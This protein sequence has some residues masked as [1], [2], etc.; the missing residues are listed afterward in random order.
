MKFPFF[1]LWIAQ[2]C[3]AF[4]SAEPRVSL[5]VD[6]FSGWHGVT[7]NGDSATL[8]SGEIASFQYP[9][10][11]LGRNKHGFRV[12]H[13]G[14]RDWREFE[15][16]EVNLASEVGREI[17][18]EAT[19]LAPPGLSANERTSMKIRAK[20]KDILRLPWTLFNSLAA[21]TSHLKFIQGLELKGR[22]IDGKP[23]F[24]QLKSVTLVKG[25]VISLEAEIRGKSAAAGSAVEYDVL[26][27]NTSTTEQSIA[28][29]FLKY[30]WEAMTAEVE[31]TNF[32]LKSG[33]T[34]SCKVR[35]TT[36]GTIPPGG[37]EKQVLQAS[38]NGDAS[39]RIEFITGVIVPSPYLLHTPKRWDEVR[40]KVK[41]YP[42]AKEAQDVV[43]KRADD[44]KVP[45]I[46]KPPGNDPDDTMGPFLFATTNEHDLMSCAI[47]WQ[48]T[49]NKAHAEKVARFLRRLSDPVNGYPKTFRA[50]NQAQVQEGHFFQHIAMSYDMIRNADVL[51][52]QDCIQLEKTFRLFMETINRLNDGGSINNWNVSEITGAFYCALAMQDLAAAD[53]FFSG[54]NGICDQLAKGTMD[55]GWWYECSISYNTWVAREF[56]QVALAYEPWGVNFKDMRLPASYAPNVLLVP[57]LNGGSPSAG[58]DPE[59]MLKPFGMDPNIFGPIRKPWR[60]IRN[61]WDGLLPFLD[62]RGVMFGVNDSTENSVVGPRPGVEPSPFEVAYYVYRDPAYASVIKRSSTRDLLYG[63]PELPKDTPEPFR[64]SA[65]ADNVGLEMLRSQTPARPIREQIQAV[66]HYGTHGWAHGHYDRTNLLSLMRYGRSF[67]NPEMVWHGYEPFMYKFYVQTSVAKNMVVVDRKMQK[68]APGTNLLFHTGKLMQAA[69]VEVTAPWGNPPYGG[70]VYDYVPVKSFA[71]KTWSEGRFVP[72]PEKAP[73]Y[74]N[75]TGYTEPIRQRRVMVVTDDYVVLADDAEGGGIHDFENLFQM[76]G[77]LGLEAKDKKLLRHDSQWDKD[78]VSSAQFV[79]D[80]D[81]YAVTAPAVSRFEMKFGPGADNAGTRALCSE[82][83]VLKLD[84]HTLWPLK[85][86]IMFGTTPEDHGLGQ[87]LFYTVRGDGRILNEGKFGAWTLGKGDVDVPIDGVKQLELETRTEL[88]KRP[89]LFWGHASVVTRDGKEIPLADLSPAFTNIIPTK[90]VNHDYDGG[91]VKIQGET[92]AFST[93]AQPENDA[94]PG[95]IRID[96]SKVDAVRFKASI[97]SD[98][99]PGPEAQ[100]RK[101]MSV[102]ADKGSKARFLTVIEPYE[103]QP[104]V[105]SAFATSGDQIRVELADG[106][107]QEI[108]IHD[109]IGKLSID[110]IESKNGKE[111]RRE[112][113][114]K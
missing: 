112:S 21:R 57:E 101:T 19:L 32:I 97:G 12:Y 69:A 36:A 7:L 25:A 40:E 6:K 50:C 20:D 17:E 107:V 65:F 110:M 56:T 55:D 84:V 81:W 114:D 24:I 16:L 14:T 45:E 108:Q 2:I 34:K 104:I 96:L 59:Q 71:E 28:L 4:A 99:P 70:M 10:G 11:P 53:R 82:D 95:L 103:N 75:I 94:Q 64:D 33:E 106:R 102:K 29:S 77:F 48:L 68:P 27:G 54:P 47:S 49:G 8:A 86:E 73:G 111:I 93:P 9:A 23:G 76:K 58:S 43:V 42:W 5:T 62:W 30:G 61:M 109:L 46:A 63:V 91:P 38:S 100:R 72:V 22:Y 83:G 31:P 26:V 1:I 3:C 51:G 15:G 60:E 78:P 37:H 52:D 44:W 87:R 88:K 79:T 105:K 80:C 98:Y 41:I 35:V 13:D 39:K 89:T 85:Q 18:L 74:G 113:T 67:Y 90:I 92:Q 66:L